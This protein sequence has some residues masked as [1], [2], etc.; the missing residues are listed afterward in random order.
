MKYGITKF[1]KLKELNFVK[2]KELNK[3]ACKQN[4]IKEIKH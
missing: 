4:I 2:K 3:I 1:I